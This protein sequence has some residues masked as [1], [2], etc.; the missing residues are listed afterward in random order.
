MTLNS[1]SLVIPELTEK[2]IEDILASDKHILADV[3]GYNEH[4]ISYHSRQKHLNSGIADLIIAYRT[5]LILIELKAVE[6]NDSM[7]DQISKY[8]HDLCKLQSEN[9]LTK[10]PITQILLVTNATEAQINRCLSKNILLKKYDPSYVLNSYYL[11]F[12]ERTVFL[13]IS[14]GDYGVVR[15][16]FLNST[17]TYLSR[18]NS[19]LKIAELEFRSIKTIRNR[20]SIAIQLDLVFRHKNSFFLTEYGEEF[21][22]YIDGNIDLL[23][24]MQRSLLRKI[25]FE[26][27]FKSQIS[28]TIL[29]IVE[30]VFI[31][32]RNNYPVHS[33]QLKEYFV[34]SVGKSDTW[35]NP[36]SKLTAT[37]IFS[38]YAVELELLTKIDNSFF[39]TPKGIN[40][41]LLL[42]LNR[43]IKLIDTQE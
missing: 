27:P 42:Q 12:K 39:L 32:S 26:S 9:K 25:V 8:F 5:Q 31:L 23:N 22:R 35:K 17:L 10:S 33:N 2:V 29:S 1:T 38:N 40:A 4:E 37:Y 28:F 20:L 21:V 13:K 6:F 7:I 41:V 18:G 34:Q 3:L 19:L 15:L 36:K 43:S 24:N 30:S 16:G 11:H 14:S